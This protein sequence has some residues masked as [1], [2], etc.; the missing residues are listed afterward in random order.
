MIGGV[1][2]VSILV[3]GRYTFWL[4][5]NNII[6]LQVSKSIM[7]QAILYRKKKCQGKNI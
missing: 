3:H 2:K 1:L 5:L 4:S 7:L 6:Y